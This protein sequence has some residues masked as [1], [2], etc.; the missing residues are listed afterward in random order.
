MFHGN[1]PIWRYNL[2]ATFFFFTGGML[3]AVLRTSWKERLPSWVGRPFDSSDFWF[4]AT[5]PLWLIVIWRYH[6]SFVIALAAAIMVAACVLPFR[7]GLVTRLLE[8][9]PLALLGVASYSL[10][11]WH[12]PLLNALTS[13]SYKTVS[14]VP[15]ATLGLASVTVPLAI[16]IAFVSYGLIERPFLR[17]R[18]RW[19]AASARSGFEPQ[20]SRPSV[21]PDGL[22]EPKLSTTA[23]VAE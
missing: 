9:R 15:G 6:Y 17:L 20:P 3:V 12:S 18:R 22:L 5:A 14:W 13:P 8:W 1:D 21:E 19:A 4:L 7:R 23:S 16:A 10:Y 2:P 11:I